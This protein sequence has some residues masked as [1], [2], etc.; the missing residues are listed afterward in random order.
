M[1]PFIWLLAV[2]SGVSCSISIAMSDPDAQVAHQIRIRVEQP[3]GGYATY[4]TSAR[5]IKE[6]RKFLQSHCVFGAAKLGY[7]NQGSEEP[8]YEGE[9]VAVSSLMTTIS[10]GSLGRSLES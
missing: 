10:S 6:L 7:K 1:K 2:L 4:G 8:S 5:N 9:A 3:P